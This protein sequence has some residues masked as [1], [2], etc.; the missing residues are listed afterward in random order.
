MKIVLL[1]LSL[2]A[3]VSCKNE[4]RTDHPELAEQVTIYRD[5]WGIPHVVG[6]TDAA[7][8]FGLA[9]AY[10]ED[11]FPEI[12]KLM[13][14]TLGREPE[15]FG[16]KD[17][18]QLLNAVYFHVFE[19]EKRAKDQYEHLKAPYKEIVDAFAAGLNYYLN[20]PPEEDPLVIRHFEPWFL[21]ASDLRSE[22][23]YWIKNGM[24]ITPLKPSILNR[25]IKSGPGSNGWALAPS[26]TASGNA[27]LLINPHDRI[28]IPYYECHIKSKEG[29]SFYGA[30]PY[31]ALTPLPLFGFNKHL[32][33]TVT[34]NS[35]DVQDAYAMT[36]DHPTDPLKYRFGDGYKTAEEQI[37]E[38]PVKSGDSIT[39]VNF[40]IKETIH[41]P[42]L[43][44]TKGK[45]ISY[46]MA[47]NDSVTLIEQKYN[48]IKASSWGEWRKAI[49]LSTKIHHN[50]TYADREGNIYYLFNGRIPKRKE[51][52]DWSKPVD[53]SDPNT[54]WQGYHNID[55]LPQVLNPECGYVQNC[56]Q[57]PFK[58]TNSENPESAEFP[59]YMTYLNDY[60]TERAV[61][62]RQLL[63][64]ASNITLKSFHKL[65]FDRKVTDSL[66]TWFINPLHSEWRAL[67]KIDKKRFEKLREPMEVLLNWN[68]Q[69]DKDQIAPTLELVWTDVA[70]TKYD[71]A[72]DLQYLQILEEALGLLE[73]E[74]GTWRVPYGRLVRVQR[75]PTRAYGIDPGKPS[76]PTDGNS[77][78]LGTMFCIHTPEYNGKS[79][80][81]GVKW[82]N[83]FV[84]H[85]EF[86]PKGPVANS[87]L[88]YG[89][90]SRPDSPHYNDQTE[91]YA[92]GEMKRVN[93]TM[94][95]I[96]NNLEAQ[97]KPG[98]EINN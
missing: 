3:L 81:R 28:K 55:E 40:N 20:T 1:F 44:N 64:S 37:F 84:A 49:D 71:Q 6:E 24:G 33:Y 57:S 29:L 80:I 75:S 15:I 70:F 7:A 12:E 78:D 32:G 18:T 67:E 97:Y 36:F 98:E 4:T 21:M 90:S 59:S 95:D 27:M 14:R 68:L 39:R 25:T 91:M 38:I 45:D 56:N 9:Y 47:R 26:K 42:V 89:N 53:G 46:R 77:G 87:L 85:V 61:R 23:D 79:L 82:G 8:V 19:I 93:F 88:S 34:I 51:N 43:K 10:A 94:E 74:F 5:T 50:L 31:W 48:M 65:N 72:P 69:S 52:Y 86:T 16:I 66:K 2:I 62:S 76:Y 73:E 22:E 58:T 41:G 30:M 17:S 83:S 96:L 63:D 54:L 13:I 60:D 35:K 92:N 11:R